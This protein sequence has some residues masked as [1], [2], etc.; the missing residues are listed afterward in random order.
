MTGLG[1]NALAS[2]I[3]L[4]CRTRADNAP[5]ISRNEFLRELR[6]E[7]PKKLRTMQQASI[8]PVDLAQAAIGPGMAIYSAYSAVTEPNGD[9]LRVRA[10]LQLINQVLDEVLTEQDSEHDRDTG[11]AV[12]WFEQYGMN[13][14]EYGRAETL[15]T[16]RA[17]SVD[18]L[19]EAGLIQSGRGRVQLIKRAD[20]PPDW[21]PARDRRVTDWEIVQYLIRALETGGRD[22]AAALKRR[23]GSRAE[24]A[25]DLAYRLYTICERKGWAQEALAYNSLVVE[26]P[27]ISK[28]VNE[29]GGER[30]EQ[31]R[32]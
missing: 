25:K 23:L 18:G 2:S 22:A 19:R 7:L 13:E 21:D 6:R 31:Q 9:R 12:S 1:T 15:A 32:L 16:A 27:A 14:A 29:L 26:W 4:S 24:I 8:A 11:W 5:A 20:L 10:A 28:A 30:I 3:I 17:V